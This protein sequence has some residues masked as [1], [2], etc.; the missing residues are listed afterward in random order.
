M[1]GRR[2]YGYVY[3]GTVIVRGQPREID[4]TAWSLGPCD[5]V[6]LRAA[7]IRD[8]SRSEAVPLA[9]L[10]ITAFWYSEIVTGAVQDIAGTPGA[11]PFRPQHPCAGPDPF[12]PCDVPED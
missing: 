2:K 7:A 8:V 6:R 11:D 3:G 10:E 12:R 5:E 4:G 9:G 1:T